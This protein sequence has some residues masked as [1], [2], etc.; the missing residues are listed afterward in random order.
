MTAPEYARGLRAIADWYEAHP[1]MPIPHT[2]Q[3]G[4][5]GVQET[6]EEA[7]RIASALRPCHKVH[8]GEF[9]KLTRD[10][11]GLTLKFVFMREAVCRRRVVGHR[12]IPAQEERVVEMVEWECEPS[13]L[14]AVEQE[15]TA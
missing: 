11:D 8:E 15:A 10:F 13:I 12:I 3:I 9:F 1:D 7:A 4:V 14:G 5:Y 2:D 6:K